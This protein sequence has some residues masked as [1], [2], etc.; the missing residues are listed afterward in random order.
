MVFSGRGLD[1]PPAHG[2]KLAV[3]LHGLLGVGRNLRSVTNSLFSAV[4]QTS[5]ATW[6]AVL[7]DLRNHGKST[8]LPGLDPPHTLT[9]AARDVIDTVANNWGGG[10]DCLAG[11]SF[12]GKVSLEVT[13]QLA[14][15]GAPFSPPKQ[16]W[17]LDAAPGRVDPSSSGVSADVLHVLE[18][19]AAVPL[20]IPSREWLYAHLEE[21]GFGKSEC[22]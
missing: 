8:G 22:E 20:P 16:V 1:D 10:I 11:H 13:R 15:V 17:V 7:V 4:A 19:V 3:V 6:T 2:H 9:T 12:G 5:G 18:S 14:Q 21:K